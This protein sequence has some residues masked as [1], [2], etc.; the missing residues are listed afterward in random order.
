MA[1]PAA[2]KVLLFAVRRFSKSEVGQRLSPVTRV[3]HGPGQTRR[4]LV[5]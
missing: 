5:H 2:A 3:F 1:G 4:A